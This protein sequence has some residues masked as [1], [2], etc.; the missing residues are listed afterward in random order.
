MIRDLK[1]GDWIF[2]CRMEPVQFNYYSVKDPN[3]YQKHMDND[4]EWNDF[5]NFDDFITIEG[6]SHAQCGCGCKRITKEYAEWFLANKVWELSGDD[7]E[8]YESKVRDL[9]KSHDINY[10]GF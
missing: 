2:T 6:S 1:K 4:E 9:C 5:I 8:L 7:W 3:D 10:E